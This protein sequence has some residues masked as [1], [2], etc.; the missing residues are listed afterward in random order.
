MIY[1]ILPIIASLALTVFWLAGSKASDLP[2]G[3]AS[4]LVGMSQA[5]Y[6]K[7]AKLG[8]DVMQA[9]R[10]SPD[11]PAHKRAYDNWNSECGLARLMPIFRQNDAR[12]FPASPKA[13]SDIYT[14]SGS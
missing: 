11:S 14:Q 13:W 6:L 9:Q 2:V 7:C 10:A 1:R 5:L 12:Q 8:H 3:E 4:P